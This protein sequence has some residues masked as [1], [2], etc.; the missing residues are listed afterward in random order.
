MKLYKVEVMDFG[1]GV[2]YEIKYLT[3]QGGLEQHTYFG[4]NEIGCCGDLNL[5]GFNL[6]AAIHF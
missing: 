1:L 6:S 3:L 4:F 2:R 5:Y